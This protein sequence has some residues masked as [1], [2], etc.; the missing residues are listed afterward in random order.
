ASSVNGLPYCEL[1]R[2]NMDFNGYLNGSGLT[3][4]VIW[5]AVVVVGIVVLLRVSNI[6]RYIPNNQVGIVEKL[7]STTGSIDG[8]F[9]AL[10]GEAATNRRCCA[11]ACPGS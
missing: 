8:G 5:T 6:F 3:A 10:N 2:W 1:W 11:A 7:W 4:P 9:I